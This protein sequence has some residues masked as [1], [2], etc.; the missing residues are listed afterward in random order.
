MKQLDTSA[1]TTTVGMPLKGGTLQFFQLA[2]QEALT[3][4]ANNFLGAKS[5]S[6]NTYILFGCLNSG[7]GG[8]FNI[9]AGAV[10][11]NGEVFLVPAASFTPGGGQTAVGTIVT[12]Q[13][14]FNADGVLFTDGITR[15]VHNIRQIVFAAAASGSGIT[16][17]DNL[18]V[19][20]VNVANEQNNTLSPGGNYTVK[21]NQQ[22]DVFLGTITGNLTIDFDLTN[23]IPG[24]VVTIEFTVSGTLTVTAGSGNTLRLDSGDLTE[25]TGNYT[26]VYFLFKGLNSA[27]NQQI[28][29][30]VN[31]PS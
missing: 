31:Q 7:T 20:G 26:S 29:Y 23:A 28:N 1:I 16:D 4:I 12:S 9:S 30:T 14:T 11:Y 13:Y 8:A 5:D 22:K 25:V 19:C 24:C 18:L 3:A 17:F 10:Y 27:G 15:N 6:T 2:Y 21:F